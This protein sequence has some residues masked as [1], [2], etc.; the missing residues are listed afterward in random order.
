[1]DEYLS[2][3]TDLNTYNDFNKDLTRN[4]YV[5]SE[6]HDMIDSLQLHNMNYKLFSHIGNIMCIFYKINNDKDLSLILDYS[7]GFNGY[8]N[9]LD[10]FAKH[11]ES[12]KVK[13][14][15]FTNDTKCKA[16]FK[17]LYY[18]K[19]IKDNETDINVKNDVNLSK[20]MIISGPNASG[21]TTL[22]KSVCINILL[23]QQFGFGCFENLKL[24]PY[25]HFHCY[26]NIPDTSGRDSLFQAEA[27]RCKMILNFITQ[28]PDTENHFAILDELY[29]G[30]NPDDAVASAH[31]F[32][33][34]ITE[35]TNVSFMLTTH[36][37]KLCK[38]LRTNKE[39]T[40]YKMKTFV[41]DDKLKYTYE[42]DKGIYSYWKK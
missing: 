29:S 24:T 23:S 41:T 20:S 31:L 14:T 3:T 40:N 27:K 2:I 19:F 9:I 16:K 28:S 42:L 25:T 13:E 7:F 22:L 1:M 17:Q 12:G 39:V 38:R 6:F 10:E 21:K 8:L 32:M 30:T 11:I 18:P 37:V 4:K 34:N 15:E 33:T 26:L 35:K 5:L 36:Y